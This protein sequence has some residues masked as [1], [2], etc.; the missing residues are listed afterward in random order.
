MTS[1]GAQILGWLRDEQGTLELWGGES[2]EG[3]D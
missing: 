2:L 3:A 1:Q